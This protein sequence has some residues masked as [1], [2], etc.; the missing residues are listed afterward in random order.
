MHSRIFWEFNTN[1][2]MSYNRGELHLFLL[3]TKQSG[4]IWRTY[5]RVNK[6]NYTN[7][8]ALVENSGAAVLSFITPEVKL[9]LYFVI[10]F[11]GLFGNVLVVVVVVGKR[12]TRSFHNIFILNLAISDLI[13]ILIYFPMYFGH[14]IGQFHAPKLFC[15]LIWPLITVAY[16]SSIF[17]IMSMAVL[18]CK[19]IINPYTSSISQ[20]SVY[21]YIA[22]LWIVAYICV[23]PGIVYA[24][25]NPYNGMCYD[26]WPNVQSKRAFT[27]FM[28][29]IQYILPLCIIAVAYVLIGLE[30]RQSKSRKLS[31][32]SRA[33]STARRREDAQV[34]RAIASIVVIFAV[35][36]FPKHLASLYYYF[37]KNSSKKAQILFRMLSLSEVFAVL[38]S[39]LN[40]LVYGTVMKHFRVEYMKYLKK[41]FCCLWR[42]GSGRIIDITRVSGSNSVDSAT[43][44]KFIRTVRS[45]VVISTLNAT[46][47]KEL[48][49]S[50]IADRGKLEQ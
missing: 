19:G 10:F 42:S 17:N 31:E 2:S 43:S 11:L 33:F 21:I 3:F 29:T 7:N 48:P 36:M 6:M 49:V 28:L 44:E 9:T 22:M 32:Q 50:W 27:L 26:A 18:R 13:L 12:R 8:I 16:L 37:G 5:P 35:C 25:V 39:C 1:F 20:R 24:E 34:V 15:Q 14:A 45:D 41:M 4:Q 46:E 47:L 23:I 40:P 30:L 38:H